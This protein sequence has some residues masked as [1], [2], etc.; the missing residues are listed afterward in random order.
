MA[1]PTR[2]RTG[3]RVA[4][5]IAVVILVP[6]LL[7]GAALALL[8]SGAVT[9]KVVD[10]VLPRASKALGREVTVRGADLDLFPN[11]RVR[12]AGLVV[13]GRP[14]EPSL[15]E[16]EGVEAEVA[17]WPL[18][19]SLG[20]NVEVRAVVLD[21]PV[22]NL[23]R[24]RDGTWNYEGLGASSKEEA[25]SPAETGPSK[26]RVVVQR[27]AIQGGA[28]HLL[29]R[30][31]GAEDA[32]AALDAID[33]EATGIGPGLPLA[34]HLG[35]ALAAAERNLVADLSLSALPSGLP[36]R[37]EEWPAVQGSLSLKALALDRLAPLLPAGTSAIVR[38]GTV[39][40]DAKVATD[41]GAY[42]LEG[43]GDARELRLR[44]QKASGRF[45]AIATAAPGRWETARLELREVAVKGPG[46]DLSG[47]AVVEQ[48]PLRA[49]FALG[50]PL[51]D[52]DA[53]MGALP[54]SE[55]AEPA[56]A[57]KSGELLPAPMRRQVRAATV[58]GTLDLG[59]L[60]SGKL[61]ATNV[62]ARAVLRDGVLVLE[63]VTAA[64]YGGK[65]ALSGTKVAVAE[66]RPTWT[67]KAKVDALDLGEAMRQVTGSAPLLGKTD[68][69]LELAGVG[70]EWEQL[71]SQLAGAAD[72]AIRDGT[73]TTADLGGK[74]VAGLA[75]GLAAVGQAGA[76]EKITTGAQTTFKEL[77]GRFA[78][79]DGWLTAQKPLR[80]A[81]PAGAVE[82]GGR[83]GLDMKLDLNGSFEVPR[84]VLARVAPP[85][86]KLPESLP[87]PL[88]LGGTFSAPSVQVRA[89]QAVKALVTGQVEAAKQAARQEVEKRTDALRKEAEKKA[90]GALDNLL[91]RFPHPK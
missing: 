32:G 3:R 65:L 63:D 58:A 55:P 20:R 33:L 30:T 41:R 7:A 82:L 27:F 5:A 38:G 39:A 78:I 59:E 14:G 51:L 12:L 69:S 62:K 36:Q 19:L 49:R 79:K 72:V 16:G 91:Q 52:L 89:D 10:A 88:G 18:L 76:A 83:V 46:V 56:P 21:R 31:A 61:R 24:A 70:I 23:V 15:V 75:Q 1:E 87:V 44:G 73:L 35:A 22:V 45:K 84:E 71:R 8:D 48:A 37:P 90:K 50:G 17:L 34:V 64:M 66:A 2:R 60:R 11:P 43:T 85:R 47:N 25:P 40:L 28:I 29:D 68:A 81:T 80:F 57:A 4:I 77:A 54:P 26:T 67:L 53:L 74:V 6:L 42:R 9:R 86:M 13:A